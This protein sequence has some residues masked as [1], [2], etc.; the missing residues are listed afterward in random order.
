M[1]MF[2]FK[3]YNDTA[4]SYHDLTLATEV[5]KDNL[6]YV[7]DIKGAA[8]MSQ[9]ESG[10]MFPNLNLSPN[11]ELTIS[12]VAQ[13]KYATGK[14]SKITSLAS[15]RDSSGTL[16]AKDKQKERALSGV[17][18]FNLPSMVRTEAK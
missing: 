6:A 3:I 7:H 17:T 9:A 2:T 8:S 12:F 15:L 4:R 13:V 5:R 16:L 14:G 11:Q 10:M 1:V 18:P